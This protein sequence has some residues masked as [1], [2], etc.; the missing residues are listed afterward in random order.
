[1]QLSDV[2]MA[3]KH[4]DNIDNKSKKYSVRYEDVIAIAICIFITVVLIV[5]IFIYRQERPGSESASGIIFRNHEKL[6]DTIRT[7]LREHSKEIRV[8]FRA[9]NAHMD[10]IELMVSEL[11]EEALADTGN[12]TEGDYIRYQYGGYEVRYSNTPDDKGYFYTVRI[13]PKY[14]TYLSDEEWV[15]EEISRILSEMDFSRKST[16][17]EKVSAIYDYVCDN[18]SYDVVHKDKDE[19]HAK[20]TAYAALRYRTAVCQGYAVLLYRLLK[21]VGVDVRVITGTATHDAVEDFHAWN[22]VCVDGVYYNVDATWDAEFDTGDYFLKSD[23]TF[24]KDHVRDTEFD[25][26]NFN[27]SYPMAEYDYEN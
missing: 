7:G 26:E 16:D 20:T 17:Y 27:M 14:Y 22:L 11:M 5:S 23:E 19:Q 4:M 18:V 15:N 12:A 2:E 25:T 3:D 6:V 9:K 13:I 10:G 8:S 24:S 1:M 21:E